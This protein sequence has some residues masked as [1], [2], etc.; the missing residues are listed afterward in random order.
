MA[1]SPLAHADEPDGRALFDVKSFGAAADGKTIDTAAVNLAIAAAAGGGTVRFPPGEYACDSIHLK[2]QSHCIFELG[3][4][5]LAASSGGFD[6]A[7]S[8]A[9]PRGST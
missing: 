3:A 9:S 8:N 2:S 7:A 4:V 5:V 6:A 1:C